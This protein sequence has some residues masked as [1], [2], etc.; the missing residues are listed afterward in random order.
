MSRNTKR[1][2]ISV[3]AATLLFGQIQ[4]AG[5]RLTTG[6]MPTIGDLVR[7]GN[8]PNAARLLKSE[9]SFDKRDGLLAL[10]RFSVLV[11][12]Q[13]LKESDPYERC[14]AATALVAYSDWTGREIIFQ[15]LAAPNQMIQKAVLDGLADADNSEALWILK[16]FY[17]AN[18][19]IGRTLALQALTEVRDP[20]VMPIFV[21]AAKDPNS[22]DAFW[23]ATGLGYVRD[24]E[25]LA[26]LRL[27]LIKSTDPMVRVQAARSLIMRGDPSKAA[28]L[29]V[30]R[31][32]HSEDVAEA[33]GAALTL[34]DKQDPTMAPILRQI[35]SE[36]RASSEIQVAAAVAL[37][38]Y[39]SGQ[40]LPVLNAALVDS[41]LRDFLM[42]MLVHLNFTLG[43]PVLLRAMSSPD[44]R[45]RLAAIE[46]IGQNGSESD[47]ALLI[48]W[49]NRAQ[50]PMDLA[51]I[52]WSLGRIGGQ[53]SIPG[54]LDLVQN[55]TP[56][57]RDTAADALAHAA[58]VLLAKQGPR[59]TQANAPHGT[60]LE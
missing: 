14:Y 20:S 15:G 43:R 44:Q 19:P 51:Q 56:A 57:V 4:I 8:I 26:H 50:D 1:L 23:A 5:S 25:A 7:A 59:G 55:P 47:V 12:R 2:L 36:K 37:T 45:V 29:T 24:N 41:R 33:A 9:Y 40:G 13:G 6:G 42:P 58:T 18:G 32:L 31:A 10:R 49:T 34:G 16:Q 22:S 38:H 54:L 28:L 21:D 35:E 11:L 17:R 48:G 53:H 46:A 52:A 3:I 27:L 39:G 30:E 60:D